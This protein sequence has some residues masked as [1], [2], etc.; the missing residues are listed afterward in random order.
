MEWLL[1]MY[2]FQLKTESNFFNR[3][4]LHLWLFELYILH[5]IVMN[6]NGMQNRAFLMSP[7]KLF[8]YD[9]TIIW[10]KEKV[11]KSSILKR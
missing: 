4:I 2:P 10:D 1:N 3:H 5:L 6:M 8:L 9:G 7:F 11:H